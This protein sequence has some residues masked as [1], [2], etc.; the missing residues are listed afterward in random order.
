MLVII[1]IQVFI[2]SSGLYILFQNTWDK[3]PTL[4]AP[5]WDDFKTAWF[6]IW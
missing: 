1:V 2:T 3:R 6:I 5:G 4:A